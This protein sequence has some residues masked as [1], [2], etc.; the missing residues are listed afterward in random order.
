M[1]SLIN[2]IR[3]S[4]VILVF[5]PTFAFSQNELSVEDAIEIGLR[6]N[7]DIIIARKNADISSNNSRLGTSGF[8][9]T[10]D[11]SGNYALS[12]SDQETNSPFSFGNSNTDGWG[13]NVSMNWTL[14]DGFKMFVDSKRFKELEKL[15]QFQAQNII[16]N[17][18]VGILRSYFNLVRE[19]LLYDVLLSTVKVSEDRLEKAKV[20]N[21]LGGSSSTDVLNAQV[22]LNNDKASLLNS[23]LNLEIARKELNIALGREPSEELNVVKK[24]DVEKD[25]FDLASLQKKAVERNSS[26]TVSEQNKLVAQQNLNSSKSFLFPRIALNANYG[27]SDRTVDSDTRGAI[28]TK[29]TDGSATLTMSFNLFNGLRNDIDIQSRLIEVDIQKTLLEKAKLELLGLVQEKFETYNKRLEFIELENQNV[30]AAEQNL[31]LQ[32]DRFSTGASSSLE[33]RDAQVNF[34][35]AQTQLLTAKYQARVA[36]LEIQQLIGDIKIN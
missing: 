2:L 23:E 15:G 26:L 8:L 7:F 33:F 18:V 36:H 12:K 4:I 9:P 11:V 17:N 27:Y 20:R 24:L 10:L 30:Q 16:E 6:N 28:N 21:E 13:A 31:R 32:E 34:S 25:S 3:I 29:S 1:K 5:I 35:R 19:E 22:A 14:F